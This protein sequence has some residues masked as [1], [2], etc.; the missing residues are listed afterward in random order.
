MRKNIIVSL[1]ILLTIT[2]FVGCSKND[3]SFNA[4]RLRISL[5]DEPI[6]TR[7]SSFTISELNVDIQ[8]IEVS[9]MDSVD[10]TENWITLD[11]N[12][13]LHNVLSLTNGKSKQIVDQYF[14]AGVLR[15]IRIFFGDNT[16]LKTSKGQINLINEETVKNGI[17]ATIN[18]SLYANYITNILVDINAALSFYEQNDNWFFKPTV[19]VFPETYGGS[20]KGYVLPREAN[21]QVIIVNEKDTLLSIP[22]SKDG[23]F[24]FRGLEEGK[25]DIHVLT[26]P[27]L[28]YKDTIFSDSVFMGQ[29]TEI[30]NKIQLLKI[31][32]TDD[33]D[34]DKDGVTSNTSD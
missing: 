1:I 29:T 20:L 13:G 22:E 3:P 24:L 33:R 21:P 32:E 27:R 19:R 10:N 30:K 16:Y 5:T 28:G 9:L 2:L 8:K 23:L 34:D 14:P 12:G 26:D 6:S 15:R 7:E 17:V 31:D 25:W 4:T 11:Y 18:T